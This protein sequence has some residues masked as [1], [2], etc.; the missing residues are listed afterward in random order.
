MKH[1]NVKLLLLLLAAATLVMTSCSKDEDKQEDPTLTIDASTTSTANPLEPGDPISIKFSANKGPDG[2]NLDE[3][4]VEF[5]ADG[6]P[7]TI[8]A[9]ETKKDLN[10][11]NYQGT[12][13][14]TARMISGETGT[15]A[16]K[17]TVIDRD[18]KSAVRTLTYNIAKEDTSQPDKTPKA[19]ADVTLSNTNGFFSTQSGQRYTTSEAQANAASVDITYFNSTAAGPNLASPAARNNSNLYGQYA[20]TWGAATVQYRTTSM[21]KAQFEALNNVD[22]IKPAYDAGTPAE[23]VNNDPGTRISGNEAEGKGGQFKADRV[24]AFHTSVGNKHGLILIKSAG[25]SSSISIKME[26]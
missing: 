10:V 4:R 3:V 12:L 6:S 24:I 2:K 14:F 13:T 25:E 18:G 20:I 9:T 5:S 19:Y 8:I 11:A 17:I 15:D 7:F 1:L 21:T 22:N 23:V 26:K 16:Y